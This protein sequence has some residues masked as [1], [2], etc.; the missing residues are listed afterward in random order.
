MPPLFGDTAATLIVDD[1]E[2]LAE[3]VRRLLTAEGYDCTIAL[4]A[5]DARRAL[6]E[7][8]FAVALVDV[9][10]PD[11]SGL[12]LV[13]DMLAQHPS[14]AVVMVTG[15]DDPE[16]AKLAID[17]GVYGYVVKPFTPSQVLITVANAS[18]RRCVEIQRDAY[19]SRLESSASAPE[20]IPPKVVA[21]PGELEQLIAEVA[22]D[23]N[24]RLGVI[25]NY[26]L[27]VSEAIDSLA[28]SGA[29][30]DPAPIQQDAD[31]IVKAADEA[32]QLV[33]KLRAG[34]RP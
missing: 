21:S 4:N 33:K 14:L 26:A 11:E 25:A 7:R 6:E 27:F 2:E 28:Q 15:V 10:M 29:I 22:H 1:D 9:M 23:L 24:G 8:E 5:K 31:R 12:V 19:E 18:M 30:A 17:G 32:A 20:A 3:T 13:N 16:V 34:S